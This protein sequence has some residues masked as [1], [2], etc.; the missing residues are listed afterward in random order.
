MEIAKVVYPT[1]T[2]GDQPY[3]GK[4]YFICPKDCTPSDIFGYIF[5]ES[6]EPKKIY[7]KVEGNW[8]GNVYELVQ[9]NRKR[10]VENEFK[11][12]KEAKKGGRI[13]CPSG[14][15]VFEIT[16]DFTETNGSKLGEPF[17]EYNEILMRECVA[18]EPTS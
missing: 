18:V 9:D 15:Y 8:Q 14:K 10:E 1:I 6:C 17:N 3:F 5:S 11:M 13:K 2:I 16:R 4:I 7:E 12:H